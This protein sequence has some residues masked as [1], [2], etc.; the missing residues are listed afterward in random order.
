MRLLFLDFESYYDN[1]FSLR[2]LT[3]AEYILDPRFETI[4]VAVKEGKA[5]GY[6]V[7]GPDF[8]EFLRGFDPAN[9]TTV[10]FN[11]LFDNCILSWLYGFTPRVMLDA[12]GMARALRGH[13]L[14]NATLKTVARTLGVGTKWDTLQKVEGMHRADIMLNP[15]LWADFKAYAT[16]DNELCAGIFYQLIPEFP[17]SEQRVMNLVLRACVEPRFRCDTDMLRQHILDL[18]AD[19]QQLLVDVG[20]VAPGQ[21][22]LPSD[23]LKAAGSPLRST[24]KFCEALEALG[25]VI[26][27]K[28]TPT[29]KTAPALAK[30]DAFMEYLQEH[31]DPRVQMLACARL[32][33]KSTI[34]ESRAQR[35]LSVASLNW[36]N[37]R[38]GNPRLYAGGTMPIPLR[39]GG[40]H[41]H[42]LSGDWK[43]N[44]QNLPTLRGSKGKSK[45][46]HALLAPPGHYVFVADL[47]QIEAR[48]VAWICRCLNL[49]QQFA[50][51]LDP[52]GILATKIFGFIVDRKIHKIEGFIGK[53]GILGLGYGA[54]DVKFFDMV[55]KLARLLEVDISG[56][57]WT[58]ELATKSVLA[59]RNTYRPIP[60]GWTRLDNILHREWLGQGNG[61]AKFGPVTISRG[62]IDLPSGLSLNYANPQQRPTKYTDKWG[63]ER[64]RMELTYQF[65]RTWHKLYG[66]K[67]L[68]NI[69]QALARIILTNAKLRINDRM[70][71]EVG[72][73]IDGR[74]VLQAHDELVYIVRDELLDILKKIV[75]EEMTRRPSWAPDLPLKVES[76][77]GRSYG[78]CK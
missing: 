55:V 49:L 60:D 34:E 10:T 71:S 29:G 44:M 68:E 67:V 50:D 56:I 77:V 33:V 16:Q 42:R 37:Y 17:W 58:P 53:T 41:T 31:P 74:F 61:V 14:D 45:L 54:G 72:A 18:Q 73:E 32:G 38:D 7:D 69:V 51:D 48:L 76:K 66:A 5:P 27:Y 26:Q 35:M 78:D 22:L 40:A 15:K 19:K 13:L 63:K 11:A 46:R 1:V 62:R 75:H 59:Y 57:G 43:M 24:P 39:Y 20:I 21:S 12:M 65:G 4:C 3:P 6:T 28:T 52:Y 30:T 9:T 36:E 8:P 47:G 25:I 70:R 23:Q 64:E 2:K